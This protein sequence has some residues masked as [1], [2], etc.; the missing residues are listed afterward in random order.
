ME[1]VRQSVVNGWSQA[2]WASL[3][4]AIIGAVGFAFWSPGRK[5]A[6]VSLGNVKNKKSALVYVTVTKSVVI[7]GSKSKRKLQVSQR[8]MKSD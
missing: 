1:Q 3:V 5:W 8:V 6:T 2:L 7:E 4:I